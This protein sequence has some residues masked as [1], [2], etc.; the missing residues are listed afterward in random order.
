MGQKL[1]SKLVLTYVG[2]AFNFVLVTTSVS[3]S[4]GSRSNS[5]SLS[6]GDFTELLKSSNEKVGWYKFANVLMIITLVLVGVILVLSVIDM[7][8]NN[9]IVNVL[10]K[11]C[12]IVGIVVSVV[13]F[14]IFVVG[15][16]VLSSSSTLA[17]I[18]TSLAYLP[19]VAPVLIAFFALLGSIFTLVALK[20]AAKK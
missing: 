10:T 18:T 6:L 7:F 2:L 5:A 1:K 9:K 3:S 8:L 11:V 17:G 15:G 19:N 4:A 20:R 12:S 16:V 13:F 14:I